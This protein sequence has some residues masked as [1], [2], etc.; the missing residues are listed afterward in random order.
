MFRQAGSGRL[1]RVETDFELGNLIAQ[2]QT[3]LF[4]APQ[5]QFIDRM[6]QA[7]SVDQAVQIGV[8]HASF[9]QAAL[10]GVKVF[11]HERYRI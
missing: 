4:E 8:L 2:Q 9:N 1:F 11:L 7:S 3:P 5:S 10:R 6:P